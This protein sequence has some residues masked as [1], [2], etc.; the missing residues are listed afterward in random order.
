MRFLLLLLIPLLLAACAKDHKTVP[1]VDLDRFMGDWYVI[2]IL[3]NPIEKNAVNG[4]ENYALK[5]DGSIAIT[6]TFRKGSPNGKQ[7]VMRPRA[8]VFN[9]QSN[10]EWRVQL[11]KPFWS[12]YLVIDLAE[13]YSHSVIGVPNRKFVWIMSRAPEL[14][15][16]VYAGILDRLKQAGYNTARIRK[17]PQIWN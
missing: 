2:A 3:P 8:K 12:P 4:I 13:D 15:D 6:Y 11:F 9:Q 17:M 5:E 14:P 7:K 10:A 16:P 1:R